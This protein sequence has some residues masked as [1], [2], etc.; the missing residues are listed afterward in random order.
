MECAI[1]VK[2][3]LEALAAESIGVPRTLHD[4][5]VRGRLAAHEQRDADQALVAR[6]RKLCR[7]AISEH[8]QQRD[9]AVGRKIHVPQRVTGFIQDLAERHIDELQVRE[10]PFPLLGGEGREQVILG[11]VVGY[12][13]GV[14]MTVRLQR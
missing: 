11:R 6:Y 13:H 5:A 9:D 1:A 7:R 2:L 10:D 3:V 8:I 12:W 4:R 14:R